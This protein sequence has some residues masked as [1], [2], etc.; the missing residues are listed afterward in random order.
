MGAG[1]FQKELFAQLAAAQCS[2]AQQRLVTLLG[3]ASESYLRRLADTDRSTARQVH[4]LLLLI[5]E[6]GPDAV[7]AAVSKVHAAGAFGADYIA[8]LTMSA[9]SSTFR[10]HGPVH[11]EERAISL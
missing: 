9:V 1:R 10:A 6:Y 11:S 7:A 2:A 3:P 4:E 8:S 5:R